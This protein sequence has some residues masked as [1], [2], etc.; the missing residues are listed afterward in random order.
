MF[1]KLKKGRNKRLI[2]FNQIIQDMYLHFS[3]ELLYKEVWQKPEYQEVSLK[4]EDGMTNVRKEFY[5]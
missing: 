4:W 1:N 3:K 2:E 5:T